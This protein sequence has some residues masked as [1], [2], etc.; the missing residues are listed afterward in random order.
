MLVYW[1]PLETSIPLLAA[2]GLQVVQPHFGR[3]LRKLVCDQDCKINGY[4]PQFILEAKAGTFH[5][6]DRIKF[7]FPL[8]N[9]AFD[10]WQ[11]FSNRLK[12]KVRRP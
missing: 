3:F 10:G 1:K 11:A 7:P 6:K 4:L 2:T 12:R 8:L 9:V 5:N